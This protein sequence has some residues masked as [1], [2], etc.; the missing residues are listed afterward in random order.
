MK[1]KELLEDYTEKITQ[2]FDEQQAI[3]NAVIQ[4]ATVEQVVKAEELQDKEEALYGK[5]EQKNKN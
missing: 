4:G 5:F 3:N 1:Y 2:D